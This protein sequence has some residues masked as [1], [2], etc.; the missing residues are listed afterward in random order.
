MKQIDLKSCFDTISIRRYVVNV[1]SP[2]TENN[3]LYLQEGGDHTLGPRF[4]TTRSSLPSF[5]VFLTYSGG[6]QLIYDGKRYEIRQNDLFIIDCR[7]KHHYATDSSFGYWGSIAFHFFGGNSDFLFNTFF[8]LNGDSPV[9]T[10]PE[11]QHFYNLISLILDCYITKLHIPANVYQPDNDPPPEIF[12]PT[13]LSFGNDLNASL[14]ITQLMTDLLQLMIK[15]KQTQSIPADFMAI[16][17]YIANN[18]QQRI[19]L[20]QLGKLFFLS[21]CYLQRT[22]KQYYGQTPSEYQIS[23][24]LNAAKNMLRYAPHFSVSEIALVNGFE[25]RSYFNRLFRQREGMTPSEYRKSFGAT[26][27]EEET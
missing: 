1:P 5:L 4:F 17:D 7:K 25:N 3:L 14:L 8:H 15:S 10:P 21:P 20:E 26:F 22:F 24:R 23:L 27:V 12:D 13:S 19:T 6:A 18:Y 2:E 16:R 11:Y 9:C